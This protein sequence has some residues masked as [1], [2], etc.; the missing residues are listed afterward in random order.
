MML[1]LLVDLPGNVLLQLTAWEPL[2]LAGTPAVTTNLG[3]LE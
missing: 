2:A 3:T 1:L